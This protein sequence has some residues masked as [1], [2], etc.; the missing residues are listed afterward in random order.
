[1]IHDRQWVFEI[2]Q[3]KHGD[4]HGWHTVDVPK[5][6]SRH[7]HFLVVSLKVLGLQTSQSVSLVRHD[8]QYDAHG[9]QAKKPASKYPDLQTQIVPLRFLLYMA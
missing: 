2:S 9:W 8:T 5:Y 4:V 1:M 6:P 3:F 7:W